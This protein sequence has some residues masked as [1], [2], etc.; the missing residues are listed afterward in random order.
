MTD[1]HD[2]M[3]QA[4]EEIEAKRQRGEFTIPTTIGL[5]KETSPFLRAADPSIR[6]NLLMEGSTDEE[7]FGEIRR[8]KDHF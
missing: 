4:L 7:V 5:E 1:P 3:R 6:R 2:P 8:R